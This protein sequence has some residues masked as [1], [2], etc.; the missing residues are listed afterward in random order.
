[1]SSLNPLFLFHKS[2]NQTLIEEKKRGSSQ[3]IHFILPLKVKKKK[4][5][6]RQSKKR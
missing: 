3:E 2:E 6:K 4:K 1:M 5:K